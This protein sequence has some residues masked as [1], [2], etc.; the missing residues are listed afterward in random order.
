MARGLRAIIVD[1]GDLVVWL[2]GAA[3]ATNEFLQPIG[4]LKTAVLGAVGALYAFRTGM[5]V[6]SVLKM[7]GPAIGLVISGASGLVGVLGTLIGVVYSLGVALLTTPVGWIIMA[8]AAV[9]AAA[10]LLYDNWDDVVKFLGDLWDAMVAGFGAMWRGVQLIAD[11]GVAGFLAAWEG[12]KSFFEGLWSFIKRGWDNSI[13]LIVAGIDKVRSLLPSFGTG[14]DG[15]ALTSDDAVLSP[16]ARAARTQVDGKL[17][18]E[19]TV[20][21]AE[22]A[23]ITGSGSSGP[24][25]LDPSLGLAGGLL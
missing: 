3:R 14:G 4:G 13:G 18:L 24:I 11:K 6:F 22:G 7:V 1:A 5:F 20:K 25:D 21:G 17:Q 15:K 8:I 23:R 10:W 12:V 19:V 9:I 16:A 2:R